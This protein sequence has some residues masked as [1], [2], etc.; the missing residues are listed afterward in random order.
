MDQTKQPGIVFNNIILNELSFFRK[1]IQFENKQLSIHFTQ[2]N[3]ILNNDKNLEVELSCELKAQS[4]AIYIKCG[5]VGIFSVI[6]GEGN[7]TLEEFSKVNAP[8]MM[9]PFIREVIASTTLRSG[10]SPIVLPPMNVN[11]MAKK[12]EE[13]SKAES[14]SL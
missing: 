1:P 13:E 6:E 2:K 12:A 14:K 10:L 4:D 11:A 3:N 5:V 7:M 8:A 9:F